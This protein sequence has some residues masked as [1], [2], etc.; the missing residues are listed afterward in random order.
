MPGSAVMTDEY[1]AYAKLSE[2]GYYHL[3]ANHSEGEYASGSDICER[4]VG[5]K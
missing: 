2:K 4:R 1:L 3:S 5:R